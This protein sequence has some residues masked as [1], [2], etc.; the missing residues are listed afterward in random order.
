MDFL[1]LTSTERYFPFDRKMVWAA[2]DSQRGRKDAYCGP[3]SPPVKS[4]Q[5]TRNQEVINCLVQESCPAW[6]GQA[7][8][9]SVYRRRIG[10]KCS[11]H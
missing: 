5:S 7:I 4:P 3:A 10:F 8:A 1:D 6:H 11:R 9:A 2:P